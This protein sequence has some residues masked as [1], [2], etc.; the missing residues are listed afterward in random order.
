MINVVGRTRYPQSTNPER[1]RYANLLHL[2]HKK[3]SCSRRS[4]QHCP[5]FCLITEL[6]GGGGA[7]QDTVTHAYWQSPWTNPHP[8]GWHVDLPH[9]RIVQRSQFSLLLKFSIDTPSSS[10]HSF[11]S[12]WSHVPPVRSRIWIHLDL[13]SRLKYKILATYNTSWG[14]KWH[15][16]HITNYF[17]VSR[18]PSAD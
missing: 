9:T 17:K 5:W 1:Y 6:G 10:E 13:H 18:S 7:P 12:L 3:S 11:F 8:A 4:Q 16:Q 14:H 2:W 15:T